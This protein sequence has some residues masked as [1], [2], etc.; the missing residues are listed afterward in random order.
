MSRKTVDRA[1]DALT[2]VT[3]GRTGFDARRS[4]TVIRVEKIMARL[5]NEYHPYGD[6]VITFVRRLTSFSLAK[7]GTWKPPSLHLE[8]DTE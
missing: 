8:S 3:Q 2:K 1:S 7:D 4:M 5:P 6:G